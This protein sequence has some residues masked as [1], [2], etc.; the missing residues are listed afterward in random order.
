MANA[1]DIKKRIKAVGNIKRITKTMQMIATSKFARAQHRALATK[2]Y[3][4][5]IFDLVTELAQRAGNIAHPL[6]DGPSDGAKGPEVHLVLTSDRGLCGPYNGNI[7]RL[8]MRQ[9]RTTGD[10]SKTSIEVVGRKG[11]TTLKFNN[12]QVEKH[13]SG[14]GD[15]TTADLVDRL[16]TEYM[17]RFT[18]G[19]ISGVKVVYMRF[20]STARQRPEVL[21]LLPLKPPATDEAE[22]SGPSAQYE[23]SPDPEQLLS[24]LL[25]EAVKST[26]FQCFNDAVVSEHVARMIAMK[27]ATDNAGKMGKNLSRKYNRARQA[28]ITTELTEIISGSAALS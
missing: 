23:F 5:G 21:Q 24:D 4:E 3:T 2:P 15:A 9:L 22:P 16:A 18:S 11:L 26:L 1:R 8:A 12:F 25:P 13:L 17:E 14:Y 28:Q 20:I 6:I 10:A 7:I 19:K 27:A